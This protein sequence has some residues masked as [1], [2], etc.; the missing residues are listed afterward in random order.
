MLP[1]LLT[2]VIA[3]P[4][5]SAAALPQLMEVQRD[6]ITRFLIFQATMFCTLPFVVLLVSGGRRG[7][8]ALAYE[9][10]LALGIACVAL[11][12]AQPMLRLPAWMRWLAAFTW[13]VTVLYLCY[14]RPF[15]FHWSELLGLPSFV[16]NLVVTA[17]SWIQLCA[18]V[19]LGAAALLLSFR[20]EAAR[21]GEIPLPRR[22]YVAGGLILVAFALLQASLSFG[23][24]TE[25]ISRVLRDAAYYPSVLTLGSLAILLG[26]VHPPGGRGTGRALLP[27]LYL[28]GACA[29]SAAFWVE[30]PQFAILGV[31]L[32]APGLLTGFLPLLWTRDRPP[33]EAAGQRAEMGGRPG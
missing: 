7:P 33:M 14:V 19:C 21:T 9:T 5:R 26:V 3:G 24:H 12:L 13:G 22:L 32:M 11:A 4:P 6:G 16:S 2:V 10:C 23:S 29:A 28:I 25:G 27:L 18:V 31:V 15:L 1:R 8:Y 20:P 17:M 30:R